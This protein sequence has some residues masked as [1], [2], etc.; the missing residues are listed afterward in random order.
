MNHNLNV[1]NK[2]WLFS[3]DEV[4][5]M[6]M[7]TEKNALDLAILPQIALGKTSCNIRTLTESLFQACRSVN[8]DTFPCHVRKIL[9]NR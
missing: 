2:R 5:F 9:N 6:S 1:A 3:C 4:I 7:N 8:A